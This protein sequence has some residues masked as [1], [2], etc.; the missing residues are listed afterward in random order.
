MNWSD[1]KS[2]ASGLNHLA[3]L[4][5]DGTVT[6]CG[7]NIHGEDS[8]ERWDNIISIAAGYNATAGLRADGRIF[9]TNNQYSDYIK[10]VNID[11]N[12]WR[13]FKNESFVEK[14]TKYANML[15]KIRVLLEKIDAEM[16]KYIKL[17]N[18]FL[19]HKIQTDVFSG[20]FK[21]GLYSYAKDIW[22]MHTECENMT[23]LHHLITLHSA[24]FSDFIEALEKTGP[25]DATTFKLTAKACVVFIT[26]EKLFKQI[27]TEVEELLAKEKQ[28][29]EGE[30]LY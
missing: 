21:S 30:I 23:T 5:K 14:Q 16:P 20:I 18:L 3:V 7:M 10:F 11:I 8:V 22:E 1:A 25:K 19:F 4:H 15:N 24:A 17:T 9:V 6:N 27:K 29:L 12:N 13:L 26:Y 28:S 2:I